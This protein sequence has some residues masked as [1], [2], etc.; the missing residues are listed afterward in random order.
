M[1]IYLDYH[2]TTPVDPLV[3]EAMSPFLGPRVGNAASRSHT[4]GR[5]ARDAVERARS[6]VAAL[7]GARNE[8]VVFTSG[9][10]ESN[11]LAL[12][13]RVVNE[14]G[15]ARGH[16]ITQPT[17]HPSVLDTCAE[18]TRR[19]A[20]VTLAS[21]DGVGRASVTE[22]LAAMRENTQLISLMLCNNEV[23]TAQDVRGLCAAERPRDALVHCDAA[24][25]LGLLPLDVREVRVDLVSLSAHKLYG[26]QGVGALWVRPSARRLL[27]AQQ[28]GG[29]HEGGLRSGT[30]NVPGIVGFGAAAALAR[31]R[32]ATEAERLASL[33]D[34]LFAELSVLDEIR[35]FGDPEENHPG[36]L[37]VAFGYTD[38]AGLLLALE[39]HLSVSSGSACSTAKSEPSHVL[40]A[41]GVP[42]A[43]LRSGLR[44]GLG[45]F[46]TEA[47]VREAAGHVVRAVRELRARSPHYRNRHKAL[48]W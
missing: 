4:H 6:Q 44:F 8:E 13:G 5:S 47:E 17:E 1:P 10:T 24:Q 29:G 31:A 15:R 14:E 32:A 3:L 16:V 26:P 30:L 38:A 19:G 28:H 37:N 18:L 46:T 41:M 42:E 7:I 11:N 23:G 9:A 39:A 35:R 2:A 12:L 45:R 27:R 25:G 20:E 34:K 48:D 33:R 36:N 40:R 22:M 43:W 21:V